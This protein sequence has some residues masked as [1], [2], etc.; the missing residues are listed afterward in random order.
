MWPICLRSC[1]GGGSCPFWRGPCLTGCQ[2][3]GSA[4]KTCRCPCNTVNITL[5]PPR[6]SLRLT[7]EGFC[8][9]VR[10]H[11]VYSVCRGMYLTGANLGWLTFVNNHPET[12]K[13]TTMSFTM[14]SGRLRRRRAAGPSGCQVCFHGYTD[15]SKIPAPDWTPPQS[16]SR[17]TL[18]SVTARSSPF[19]FFGKIQ[20]WA[21]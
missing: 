20:R 16:T 11:G 19:F 6:G 10:G 1:R 9:D 17:A 13:M 12:A 5:E 2:A 3:N 4:L 21:V 18:L 8:E 7:T 15:L 14:P